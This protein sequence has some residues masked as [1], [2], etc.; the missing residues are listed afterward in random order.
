MA[1]RSKLAKVAGLGLLG[2]L[3]LSGCDA[4][5]S[6]LSWGWPEGITDEAARR[7]ALWIGS[8]IAALVVGIAWAVDAGSPAL[9]AGVAA[10]IFLVRVLALLRHW[11]GPRAR[12]A[13]RRDRRGERAT[14]GG[15]GAW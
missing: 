8:T 14:R 3:T 12:G 2:A 6:W 13:G 9:G 7:H 10:G 4:R 11:R 1:R 5:G 15:R